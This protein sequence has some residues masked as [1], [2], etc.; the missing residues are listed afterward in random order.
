[1]YCE[2]CGKQ[3]IRGYQFCIECGTPVPPDAYDE[4]NG[5]ESTP[6]NIDLLEGNNSEGG[7]LVFCPNCGMRIQNSTVY[8]E[9]CGIK[10]HG[11]K[12]EIPLINP[13]PVDP[14][15]DYSDN[16]SE[17]DMFDELNGNAAENG[18]SDGSESGRSSYDNEF[19]NYVGG[20]GISPADETMFR[21]AADDLRNSNYGIGGDATD[22]E[23][24]ELQKQLDSFSA[25]EEIPSISHVQSE[26][27]IIRQRE[28]NFGENQEVDD[29]AMDAPIGS[30]ETIGDI[31][32]IEGGS[33][34]EDP[35]DDVN[36][37]PYSFVNDIIE[38]TETVSGVDEQA[39]PEHIEA[40]STASEYVLPAEYA[41]VTETP[42]SDETVL[43]NQMPQNKD[44]DKDYEADLEDNDLERIPFIDE[45]APV[46]KETPPKPIAPIPLITPIEPDSSVTVPAQRVGSEILTPPNIDKE[47]PPVDPVL[48]K[49]TY[50]HN[51][52]QNMY[53]NEPFCKHCNAPNA[54]RIK[55]NNVSGGKSHKALF[56]IFG[57]VAAAAAIAGIVIALNMNKP[58]II[59]DKTLS[60][61]DISSELSGVGG[62][63]NE[64]SDTPAPPEKSSE[65][66]LNSDNISDNSSK[67]TDVPTE[68]DTP[69]TP[70][71]TDTLPKTDN[72]TKPNSTKKSDTASKPAESSKP[73]SSSEE[74]TASTQ[75]ST[76]APKPATTPPPATTPKP[77]TTTKP[78]TSTKPVATTKPAAN[79]KPVA[80]TKP[81][82]TTAPAAPSA[83]VKALEKERKAIF[84]A[85]AIIARE[86]GKLDMF[87]KN[88]VYIM[89]NSTGN[90]ETV[91]SSYYNR[92]FAKNMLSVIDSGK[93]SVD[94]AV[95]S[96]D[97]KSPL[98]ES[99]YDSLC[100]LQKKYNAYYNYIKSPTGNTSKFTN[101][102]STYLSD[103]YT[104]LAKLKYKKTVTDDYTSSD[105]SD[106]Y[107]SALKSAISDADTAVSAFSS[108][109]DK[110][111]ALSKSSFESESVLELSKSSVTE[112]YAKA[113][114]YSYSVSAYCNMLSGAPTGY[115]DA[116][117]AL[118]AA[119]D[120]LLA[121]T[122]LHITI[123]ENSLSSYSTTSKNGVSAAKNSIADA[124]E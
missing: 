17:T 45:D 106:V 49:L 19:S 5:S 7:S 117:K 11:A 20:D 96:A 28:P 12:Q 68:S 107:S 50:C 32:V 64:K 26:F 108:L 90:S 21:E 9:Q 114:A 80:A 79:T 86:V 101:N 44:Y 33:M 66:I 122:D 67:K 15:A 87:A 69:N 95:N 16:N 13:N 120:E 38:E 72:S 54:K 92:D 75:T 3:L 1:M 56:G 59:D 97:P 99:V 61:S 43:I 37:D 31:P 6:E 123:G 42:D 85:A 121:L 58:D 115:S 36:L 35:T 25:S 94:S 76:S 113:A 81:A 89:D 104:A 62:S 74:T 57:G 103:F 83:A 84:D 100:L 46:I 18:G 2:N 88:V 82:T 27:E 10:L 34:D 63:D 91:R 118:C 22:E 8:C 93:S 4:E 29:F 40:E 111:T 51:C 116:Y 71:K 110:L 55:I 119:R 53:E 23:L 112:L 98:L 109:R 105:I 70:E 77:A 102:C 39:A 30:D 73:A 124:K 65:P 41:A 60:N 52:G 24:A 47:A 14:F 78:A 48:G